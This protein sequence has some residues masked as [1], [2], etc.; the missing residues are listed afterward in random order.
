MTGRLLP[1]LR[2]VDH[3][4][5]TVPDLDEAVRFFVEVLGAEEL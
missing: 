4:A 5:Y 3:A 1:G 2:H